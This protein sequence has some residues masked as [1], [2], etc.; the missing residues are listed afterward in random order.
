MEEHAVDFVLKSSAAA[1]RS[2]QESVQRKG[3]VDARKTITWA[4][5]RGFLSFFFWCVVPKD[6]GAGP[7]PSNSDTM[8][9]LSDVDV[10]TTSFEATF[11]PRVYAYKVLIGRFSAAAVANPNPKKLTFARTPARAW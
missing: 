4:T 2:G 10:S 11:T 6:T 9:L 1:L 3:S 7:S 8:S 5:G